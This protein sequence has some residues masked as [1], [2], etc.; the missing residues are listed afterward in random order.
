MDLENSQRFI[1]KDEN[2]WAQFTSW[3]IRLANQGQNLYNDCI[4][5]LGALPRKAVESLP[6]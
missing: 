4:K 6:S 1:G 3:E 5:A 2:Q